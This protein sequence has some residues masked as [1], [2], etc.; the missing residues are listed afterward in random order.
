MKV[1]QEVLEVILE[2]HD[3]YRH[4]RL[5]KPVLSEM[6]SLFPEIGHGSECKQH[7]PAAWPNADRP[8]IYMFFGAD[9][10]LI[11]I[12]KAACL[13]VRLGQH[14]RYADGRGSGCVMAQSGW[15][16]V[17]HFVA[18][19]AIAEPFEATS[20]EEYLIGRLR[21]EENVLVTWSAEKIPS[22]S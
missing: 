7:W 15:K 20:L 14:F 2:Y 4:P 21:P 6:F 10:E 19:V 12:G 1:P 16:K 11:Y 8:G 18:T 13:G 22:E 3:L 5:A 17:P 9:L